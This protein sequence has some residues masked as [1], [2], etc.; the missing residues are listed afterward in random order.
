MGSHLDLHLTTNLGREGL[1]ADRVVASVR[2]HEE[3][4][5]TGPYGVLTLQFG[6]DSVRL[7]VDHAEARPMAAQLA[8]DLL[9]CLPVIG[10]TEA[11]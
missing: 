4:G 5:P 3:D 7:F 2:V 8:S 1:T 10:D 11:A 9:A 6:T